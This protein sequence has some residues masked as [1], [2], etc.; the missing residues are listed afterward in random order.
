VGVKNDESEKCRI[1]SS[2]NE[3]DVENGEKGHQVFMDHSKTDQ[4][5]KSH[6]EMLKKL[7]PQVRKSLI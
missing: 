5:G 2:E 6:L 1:E 3:S 7:S 4:G